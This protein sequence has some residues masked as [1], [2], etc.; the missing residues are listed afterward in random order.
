MHM[1]IR[2]HTQASLDALAGSVGATT[3]TGYTETCLAS[4]KVVGIMCGG[5]AVQA[6]RAG[7]KVEVLLDATPFYAGGER[8]ERHA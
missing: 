5:A 8:E 7:D 6:A 4:S 3:F 2:V 1:R